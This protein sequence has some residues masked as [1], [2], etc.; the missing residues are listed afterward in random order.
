MHTILG[1]LCTK[2]TLTKIQYIDVFAF[3]QLVLLYC[4]IFLYMLVS[5]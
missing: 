2:D 4:D 5:K 3:A 1:I